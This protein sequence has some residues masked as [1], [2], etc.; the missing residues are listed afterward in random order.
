MGAKEGKS[1]PAIARFARDLLAKLQDEDKAAG[2]A[3]EDRF[4]DVD[5]RARFRDP[6]LQRA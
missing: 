6:S 3:P 2:I 4:F 5:L 1:F